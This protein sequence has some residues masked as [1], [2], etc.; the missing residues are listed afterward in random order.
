MISPEEEDALVDKITGTLGVG[1]KIAKTAVQSAE[2]EKEAFEKARVLKSQ[3]EVAS[4]LLKDF[5]LPKKRIRFA[6][7]MAFKGDYD[8]SKG[9]WLM[10][11]SLTGEKYAEKKAK[12][13]VPSPLP[14][15]EYHIETLIAKII[16]ELSP[17]Y[18]CAQCS[19]GCPVFLVD[20][21]TNPRIFVEELLLNPTTEVF[22]SD[23][24]WQCCYCLNCSHVCPHGVDLAH[25]FM[26]TRNLAV[27][28]GYKAPKAFMKEA[29]IVY[30]SGIT[31]EPSKA[32]LKRREKLGLPQI[33]QTDTEEVKK[34]LNKTGFKATIDGQRSAGDSQEAAAE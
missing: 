7:K 1:K 11:R 33:I 10:R 28:L 24:I 13:I 14:E 25:I 3:E 23:R 9:S 19:S 27:Q 2:T 31:A 15:A 34:L 30:E 6:R 8:V 20:P 16:K 22:G 4:D 18:Q 32:I 21:S 26:K 12:G 5:E 29:E 17:C